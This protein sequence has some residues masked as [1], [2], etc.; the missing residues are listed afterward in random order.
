M[1]VFGSLPYVGGGALLPRKFNPESFG[2]K[3]D[4]LRSGCY[5]FV[6]ESSAEVEG[7]PE[8]RPKIRLGRSRRM[9]NYTVQD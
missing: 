2:C 1:L 3:Q 5:R 8:R 7:H 4:W 9:A 6:F